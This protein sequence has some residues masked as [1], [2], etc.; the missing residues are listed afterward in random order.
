MTLDVY[1]RLLRIE[2]RLIQLELSHHPQPNPL[3]EEWTRQSGWKIGKVPLL[4]HS[5]LYSCG[6]KT[7]VSYKLMIEWTILAARE[8]NKFSASTPQMSSFLKSSVF[9][10]EVE[11]S[12][13]PLAHFVSFLRTR[14]R[15]DLKLS[16]QVYDV[17][18]GKGFLSALLSF[19]KILLP[20]FDVHGVD[21]VTMVDSHF[22]RMNL[23]HVGFLNDVFVP[24]GALPIRV[25]SLSIFSHAFEEHLLRRS[26]PN[27]AVAL[28]GIHL[29]RRLSPRMIY[30]HQHC[31]RSLFMFLG[32]CCL[33][34][35]STAI[36][37]CGSIKI[38]PM[39][40]HLKEDS[41]EF[42]VKQ[43]Y[44]VILTPRFKKDLIRVPLHGGPHRCNVFIEAQGVSTSRTERNWRWIGST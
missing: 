2:A 17:C 1:T 10:S 4:R 44:N 42:W 16:I 40:V 5:A 18:S 7:V 41:Y 15:E 21:V 34:P 38:D 27:S 3:H 37:D 39:Q 31:C 6:N 25:L 36:I 8:W 19:L 35:K 30:L 43:L 22:D 13:V 24:L 20:E 23:F 14:N 12:I 29:C 11:E 26:M 32:P 28:L 33:P 9:V